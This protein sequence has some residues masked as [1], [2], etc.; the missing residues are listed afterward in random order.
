MVRNLVAAFAVRIDRLDWMAPQTRAK[1]KEKLATL[2]VGVGYPDHWRDFSGLEV[3]RGDAFGNARRAQFPRGDPATAELRPEA[4]PGDGL[5]GDRGCD[6]TRD[7]PQ[8]R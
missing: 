5:R 3:V 1:A 7:Q 8:L 2:K 4:G 6:R